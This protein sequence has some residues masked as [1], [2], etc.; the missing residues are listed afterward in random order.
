[1]TIGC[2][3]CWEVVYQ[4][5]IVAQF[6]NNQWSRLANLNQRRSGHGSITIGEETMII[7]GQAPWSGPDP[8]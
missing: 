4:S 3:I 8:E 7:G 2:S 1:L 5:D 6:K